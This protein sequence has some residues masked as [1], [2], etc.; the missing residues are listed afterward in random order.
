MEAVIIYIQNFL[1][2]TIPNM[3]KIKHG[4]IVIDSNEQ[5]DMFVNNLYKNHF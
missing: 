3:Y 5:F 2:G 1:N 4:R